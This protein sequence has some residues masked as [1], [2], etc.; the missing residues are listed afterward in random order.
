MV[1][2]GNAYFPVMSQVCPPHI[3]RSRQEIVFQFPQPCV[4]R[5]VQLRLKLLVLPA[6]AQIVHLIRIA[7]IVIE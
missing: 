4:K 3:F 7:F 2:D 5:V 6:A 1:P